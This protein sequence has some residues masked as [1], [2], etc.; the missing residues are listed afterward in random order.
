MMGKILD[1]TGW[2]MKD[3]GVPDSQWKVLKIDD[4]HPRGAGKH[5]FWICECSCENHTIKSIDGCALRNGD[6]KSCG[7]LSKGR[8]NGRFKNEVGNKYNHLTVLEYRGTDKNNKAIWLVQCDCGSQPF[9][10]LGCSLRSGNTKSCGC[11]RGEKIT[12]NEQPGTRYGKLTVLEQDHSLGQRYWKCKCDCGNTISVKGIYLRAGLVQSCGCL[13]SKG[14]EQILTWLQAHNII[15]KKE[16]CFKDLKTL[17]N[18]YPRFDFAI[19][20]NNY[21]LKCLIEFQGKQ[22][23][24]NAPFGNLQRDV[25]DKLK[26]DYCKKNNLLLH[27]INYNDDIISSLERI[28][29][30]TQTS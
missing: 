9:E 14:E 27:K 3:H 5:I 26:E 24:E 10:V 13:I 28:I 22:H 16:Y 21:T 11:A 23:Y 7:C 2:V 15:Y 29:Y 17:N 20:D 1:M 18:G 12:I 4:S 30:G 19:F 8:M 6:S 25:T